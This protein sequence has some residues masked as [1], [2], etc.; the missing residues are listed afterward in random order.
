MSKKNK[1]KTK[2]LELNKQFKGMDHIVYVNRI[3]KLKKRKKL[4][5][6]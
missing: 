1:K 4:F 3:H 2:K 6:V 5:N